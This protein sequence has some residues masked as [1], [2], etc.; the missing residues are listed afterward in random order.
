M[1]MY[2][3]LNMV[4][5]IEN[6]KGY[7]FYKISGKKN[8]NF[9]FKMRNDFLVSV[10]KQILP[11][12][13]ESVFDEIYLKH[14]PKKIQDINNPIVLDIGANVGYFTIF[15][16]YKFKNPRIISFEPMKRNFAVLQN[17]LKEAKKEN[18]T[19]VNKAVNDTAG[20]LVLKFNKD[21]D[22]T[23][24]ASLFDNQYGTD[25]EIVITTTLENAFSEYALPKIDILKLDC[26]G[27]EYNIIYKTPKALFE[28]VNCITL[29][30]HLGK[31]KNENTGALATY[32]RDL[33]FTVVTKPHFIWAYKI[34]QQWI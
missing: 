26:E 34:P 25:E 17:N 13:K 19:I 3:T 15:C 32:L 7:L 31:D 20:Q 12:F 30:T 27:A 2:R 22:I 29:E 4:K 33:G 1:G 23:T 11:E 16:Q 28:K 9:V 18:L 21:K 5:N 6:W 8:P 24:S 10:P 14:L